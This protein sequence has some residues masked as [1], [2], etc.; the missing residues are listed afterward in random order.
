MSEG[1]VDAAPAPDDLSGLLGLTVTADAGPLA[2]RL[3]LDGRLEADTVSLV[4]SCIDGWGASGLRHI[5]VDLTD[6]STVDVNAAATLARAAHVLG[7]TGGS[8]TL[9]VPPHL[10]DGPL[11]ACGLDLIQ[12]GPA[13][14]GDHMAIG[15]RRAER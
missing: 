9:L 8:L 12:P 3:V 4:T 1:L 7:R 14:D 15:V 2:C 13:A 10:L 5:V 11:A 6:V